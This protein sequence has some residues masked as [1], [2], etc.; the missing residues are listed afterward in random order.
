MASIFLSFVKVLR[1]AGCQEVQKSQNHRM[2]WIGRNHSVP[3]PPQMHISY[4]PDQPM[5]PKP[6]EAATDEDGD[7]PEGS[8]CPPATSGCCSCLT[9]SSV[10]TA[11]WAANPSLWT[12]KQSMEFVPIANRP[13]KDNKGYASACV[14]N[15]GPCQCSPVKAG[16]AWECCFRV[17][18]GW[19]CWAAFAH[20]HAAGALLLL[21]FL[22]LL[23]W[24]CKHSVFS[25]RVL[26]QGQRPKKSKRFDA[27]LHGQHKALFLPLGTL[28]FPLYQQR[29]QHN[30]LHCQE[31]LLSCTE[32]ICSLSQA[33]HCLNAFYPMKMNILRP[34]QICTMLLSRCKVCSKALSLHK[35]STGI[36]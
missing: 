10:H 11:A 15:A 22:P 25:H 18:Q 31:Y 33:L 32:F 23:G 34:F 35:L 21:L 6:P 3:I 26:P 24:E 28:T 30:N 19:K 20:M 5:D 13:G 9:A 12:R 16:T 7:F 1:T 2:T 17:Q 8:R 27:H 36:Q 29:L 14:H 4:C